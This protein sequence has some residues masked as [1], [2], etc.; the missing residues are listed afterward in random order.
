MA[1]V[2]EESDEGGKE[3]EVTYV[4]QRQTTKQTGMAIFQKYL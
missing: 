1:D 3:E 4:S 2:E